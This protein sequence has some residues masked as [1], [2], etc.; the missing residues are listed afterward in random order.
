WNKT[1]ETQIWYWKVGPLGRK[2]PNNRPGKNKNKDDFQVAWDL[3]SELHWKGSGYYTVYYSRNDNIKCNEVALIA[4]RKIAKA[5][6]CF[7]AIGDRIISVRFNAKPSSLTIWQVYEPTTDAEEEEEEEEE[8]EDVEK[9][10][11]ELQLAID[12]VP[13]KDIFIAGDFNAKVDVREEKPVVGKCRLG[14]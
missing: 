6:Q 13:A 5:V 12:Q 8:E 7:N 14:E 11:G 4:N 3:M 10:Y 9:F 2:A 1:E